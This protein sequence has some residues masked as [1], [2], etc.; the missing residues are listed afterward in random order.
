VSGFVQALPVILRFE[1]GFVDDPIDRG[2]ATNKG[3]TQRTFDAWRVKN[4][5]GKV[6]VR[7]ITTEEVKDIYYRA[8]WLAGKCDALPWP[9]SLAHFDA[10][11]NHG[12]RNAAKLLQRAVGATPDGRIGPQTLASVNATP[13]YKLVDKLL[14]GRVRFYLKIVKRRPEQIKFLR[15]WLTRVLHLVD[16]TGGTQ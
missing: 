1:G 13:T 7:D 3:I 4:R 6:S 8:Y 12:L 9:A 2:G 10:S 15:G 14:W 16:E 5:L 11:V